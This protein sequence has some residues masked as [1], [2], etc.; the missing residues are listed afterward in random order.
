MKVPHLLTAPQVTA[1]AQ[2]TMCTFDS[3]VFAGT[4]GSGSGHVDGFSFAVLQPCVELYAP[5]ASTQKIG[6]IFS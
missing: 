2:A 5:G 3:D 1:H 4:C 6:Q